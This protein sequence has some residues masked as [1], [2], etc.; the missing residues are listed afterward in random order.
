M[1]G[2]Q[3]LLGGTKTPEEIME[4]VRNEAHRVIEEDK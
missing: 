2:G 4:A 1:A 3:E